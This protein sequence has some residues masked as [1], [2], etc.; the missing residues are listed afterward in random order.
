MAKRHIIS[1][2]LLITVVE[3]CPHNLF[4]FFDGLDDLINLF[5]VSKMFYHKNREILKQFKLILLTRN[6]TTL[7]QRHLQIPLPKLLHVL[8]QSQGM[9]AGGSVL[10]LFT[11][12]NSEWSDLDFFVRRGP[13]VVMLKA[14]F[15][16]IGYNIR[17]HQSVKSTE[18]ELI[19]FRDRLTRRRV[20]ILIHNED[21]IVTKFDISVCMS[22]LH[23]DH[24]SGKPIF[25]FRDVSS[26]MRRI[27]TPSVHLA[28]REQGMFWYRLNRS[29]SDADTAY[30][31][32]LKSV[33]D[34]V[35]RLN[36]RVIKYCRR[37][38][39]EDTVISQLRHRWMTEAACQPAIPTKSQNRFRLRMYLWPPP[40]DSAQLSRLTIEDLP[41]LGVLHI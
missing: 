36:T 29:T 26:I 40:Y 12:Y 14:F 10:H 27:L 15:R 19:M 23:V 20:Q 1:V 9:L 21:D 35:H 32:E 41:T 18:R 31:A 8:H 24:H 13:G 34:A 28:E 11:G 4:S 7:V 33:R 3:L 25:T 6:L 17:H 2:P 16:S 5:V 38:Y 39:T 37:G 22:S 30:D